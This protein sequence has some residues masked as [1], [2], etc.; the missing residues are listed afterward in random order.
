MLEAMVLQIALEKLLG[1]AQGGAVYIRTGGVPAAV[2]GHE[3][4]GAAAAHGVEKMRLFRHVPR[5]PGEVD[6]QLGE[7]LVGLALVFED[8]G[9]VAA[10]A[11]RFA[12]E[13][14]QKR[15]VFPPFKEHVKERM[16]GK[17]PGFR[18]RKRAR[19]KVQRGKA[20]DAAFFPSIFH[21]QARERHFQLGAG[22]FFRFGL[23]ARIG[24]RPQKHCITHIGTPARP[25][26][27]ARTNVTKRFGA[28]R[29]TKK[30][31]CRDTPEYDVCSG[32]R[33]KRH[34]RGSAAACM[35]DEIA[36]R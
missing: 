19:G 28:G 20:L 1:F 36:K 2:E 33:A 23:I 29:C 27:A 13:E 21:A 10:H 25:K 5:E 32:K 26:R 34:R 30:L 17:H 31:L 15:A 35:S 22:Q 16:A 24:M 7:H 12:A 14:G 6:K 4:R 11:G 9:K 8:A 18:I 3:Q